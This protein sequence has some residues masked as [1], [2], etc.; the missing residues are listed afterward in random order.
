MIGL[1]NEWAEGMLQ[2]HREGGG[3]GLALRHQVIF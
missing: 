3:W 1:Y 2:G